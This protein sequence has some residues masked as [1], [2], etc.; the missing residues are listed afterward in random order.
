VKKKRMKVEIIPVGETT[1]I[2]EVRCPLCRAEIDTVTASEM[3]PAS[4]PESGDVTVCLYCG[5][6]LIIGNDLKPRKPTDAELADIV[7]SKEWPYI[8]EMSRKFRQSAL[9]AVFTP[10]EGKPQ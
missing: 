1:R 6:V 10:E 2:G 9:A 4:L 7:A 5:A 3:N 8:R